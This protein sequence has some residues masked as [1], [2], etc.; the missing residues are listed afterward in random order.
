MSIDKFVFDTVLEQ[1]EAAGGNPYAEFGS[2]LL[3]LDSSSTSNLVLS[4]SD[5][6]NWKDLSGNHNNATWNASI[7]PSYSVGITINGVRAVQ[8]GGDPLIL[9]SLINQ[10][11]FTIFVVAQEPTGLATGDFLGGDEGGASAF[12]VSVGNVVLSSVIDGFT[13]VSAFLSSPDSPHIFTAIVTDRSTVLVDG[14]EVGNAN[15]TTFGIVNIGYGG[16]GAFSG[17]IGLVAIYDGILDGSDISGVVNLISN[18]W[19][20]ALT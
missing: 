14:L 15:D 10:M 13:G 1:G 2:L 19:S 4:G 9:N 12:G 17:K 7:A 8:F 16:Q 18:R 11:P 6:T 5:V 3:L 20:I